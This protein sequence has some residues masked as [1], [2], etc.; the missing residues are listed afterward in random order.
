AMLMSG[1]IRDNI[2]Y[3]RSDATDAEVERV[4]RIAAIHDFI[5]SLPEGYDTQV[6]QEGLSLSGGQRQRIALA[7]ALLADADVL[8]LDDATSAVDVHVER[9][10]LEAMRE[11]VA[12][13]TVL[14]VAYRESTV[15]LA[16]RV[17]RFDGGQVV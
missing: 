2:A 4:A 3:G 1:S 13:R 11:V 14:V 17:V 12:G 6:G 7:R 16:D 5:A 10:I 8:V 15:R 9:Q